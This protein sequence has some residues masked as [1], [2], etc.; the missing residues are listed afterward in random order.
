MGG[1]ITR[2][3]GRLYFCSGG[4]ILSV[5]TKKH[6]GGDRRVEVKDAYTPKP[7]FLYFVGK[8]GT[9]KSRSARAR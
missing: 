6:G 9:A 7:G 4:N 3:P 8:D 5:R 2:S 1:K